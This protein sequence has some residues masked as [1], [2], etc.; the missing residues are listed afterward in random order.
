MRSISWRYEKIRIAIYSVCPLAGC[1]ACAVRCHCNAGAGNLR[2]GD[3]FPQWPLSLE[4]YL[5]VAGLVLAGAWTL[6]VMLV[7]SQRLKAAS[8]P[9]AWE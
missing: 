5:A 3:A 7:Y 4:V 2:D 6:V 8:E 9:H 1:L